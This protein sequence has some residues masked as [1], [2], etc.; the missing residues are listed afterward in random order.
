MNAV[1]DNPSASLERLLLVQRSGFEAERYPTVATRRDRLERLRR[2]V[3]QHES[4]ASCAAIEQRLRPSVGAR[5]AARRALHRR[6]RE[7]ATR[8]RHL[9]ALDAAAPR[10]DAAAPAAGARADRAA[11]ASAS[12]ASSARG[13]IRCSWR[14]RRSSRALAAGN[15]VMLKPSEL[16]PA[17]SAL[18]R[19][20]RR[21]SFREDEFAV[22]DGDADV[23]AGVRAPAVRSPVLHR[24]DGRGPAGRAGGG[25]EPDA[26]HA[27]ARRQIAGAV[28]RR[29]RFRARPR[30]GS[31]SASC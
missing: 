1:T 22:V 15:R 6:R 20:L 26:G 13:T 21:R 9:V 5:D 10:R 19:E 17:T 18:L 12:S 24:L 28:R 16:T 30:R 11:A 7:R 27:G 25:R 31:S 14:W 4:R 2:I 23:G 3:T 8:M 29:R